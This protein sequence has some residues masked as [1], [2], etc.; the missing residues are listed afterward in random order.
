MNRDIEKEAVGVEERLS[1]QIEFKPGARLAEDEI[2]TLRNDP[3]SNV[4]DHRVENREPRVAVK[5]EIWTRE[6]SLVGTGL[7]PHPNWASSQ[8]C[9]ASKS[10][11]PAVN[12]MAKFGYDYQRFQKGTQRY[13]RDPRSQARLP[14]HAA[15]YNLETGDK[16]GSSSTFSMPVY[17]VLLSGEKGPNSTHQRELGT[18]HEYSITLTDFPYE[19]LVFIISY[20]D[21]GTAIFLST[22]C[23]SLH[24]AYKSIHQEKKVSL[25]EKCYAPDGRVCAYLGDMLES[26]M[27][28]QY[29]RMD[30]STSFNL[31]DP[32]HTPP[33]YLNRKVYGD[34]AGKCGDE[35]WEKE[36][37]LFWRYMDYHDCEVVTNLSRGFAAKLTLR[38]ETILPHPFNKGEDWDAEAKRA[39]IEDAHARRY[40]DWC[41]WVAFWQDAEI[42]RRISL[43]EKLTVLQ[44]M[45]AKYRTRSHLSGVIPGNL[46]GWVKKQRRLFLWRKLDLPGLTTFPKSTRR[47]LRWSFVGDRAGKPHQRLAYLPKHAMVLRK[48]LAGLLPPHS[49]GIWYYW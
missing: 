36:N 23:K 16:N 10:M 9:D 39:V 21:L 32:E 29:R 22:T 1:D 47:E 5:R 42:F 14:G 17:P 18:P 2:L 15:C 34:R 41:Q 11:M 24:L 27:K 7:A 6:T 3:Q 38:R 30:W 46:R 48:S 37:A 8:Q 19:I 26:W 49:E 43:P 12:V 44:E 33:Q 4:E 20:L 35:I 40:P 31:L 28:P 13:I 25:F 45:E